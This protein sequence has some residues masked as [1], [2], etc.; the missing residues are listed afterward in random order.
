[1][2]LWSPF[3]RPVFGAGIVGEQLSF[4][5]VPIIEGSVIVGTP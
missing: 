4:T 5:H 1:M 2:L 3:Y